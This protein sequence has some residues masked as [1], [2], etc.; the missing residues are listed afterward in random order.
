MLLLFAQ[1]KQTHQIMLKQFEVY[2]TLLWVDFVIFVVWLSL[3]GATMA[4]VA[5]IGDLG[6]SVIG[7]DHPQLIMLAAGII[8]LFPC[9]NKKTAHVGWISGLGLLPI[10]LLLGV[11]WVRSFKAISGG[12]P[13]TEKFKWDLSY[14][15]AFPF[16]TFAYQCHPQIPPIY[17]E[18]KDKSVKKM[19]YI[20]SA[21]MIVESFIYISIGVLGYVAFGSDTKANIIDNYASDDIP[22]TIVRA[23]MI[24]HFLSAIPINFLPIRIHFYQFLNISKL[25]QEKLWIHITTTTGL[26]GICV[27]LAI[28]AP[29]ASVFFSLVGST[30]GVV[31]IFVF[32]GL[33]A[34]YER[35]LPWRW[36]FIIA[37]FLLTWLI[38]VGG[39]AM[40]V[41]GIFF[42]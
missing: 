35:D 5:L 1:R 8:I 25:E 31:I 28:V 15:D 22:M 6:N 4:Y 18:L 12:L 7:G 23:T 11:V 16:F 41:K 10:V 29:G 42:D 32:P 38:G 17:S 9:F 21:A 13:S 2:L 39:T 27:F 36:P 26:L 14:L 19:S 34:Y 24:V 33:F 3:M 37:C 30:C 40:T 20:V